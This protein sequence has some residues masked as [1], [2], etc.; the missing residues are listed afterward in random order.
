MCLMY[1][2]SI[3]LIMLYC[4]FFLNRTVSSL[5]VKRLCTTHPGIYIAM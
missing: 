3:T 4:N 2:S 1:N 5:H